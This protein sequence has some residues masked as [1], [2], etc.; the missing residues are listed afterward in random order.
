MKNYFISLL[1]LF[2]FI[3]C[4]Q[5]QPKNE[6]HSER[7]L[8]SDDCLELINTFLEVKIPE[9][10]IFPTSIFGINADI[11]KKMESIQLLSIDYFQFYQTFQT[12]NKRAPTLRE[13]L[14]FA[15]QVK[16][17]ILNNYENLAEELSKHANANNQQIQLFIQELRHSKS[18]LSKYK[19]IDQIELEVVA[20]YQN[21]K[22]AIATLDTAI[23]LDPHDSK[24]LDENFYT[25]LKNR[26][27]ISNFQ[28]EF[29]ELLAQG[30]SKEKV[31]ARGLTFKG[32]V[33]SAKTPTETLIAKK[34]AE[35][36]LKV[37]NMTNDQIIEF[38]G[39]YKDGLFRMA[40]AFIHAGNFS[41]DKR[42]IVI[43]KIF[44]MIKS[45]EIDLVSETS[46]G[47]IVWSEV[48]A[49]IKPI[50]LDT[51]AGHSKDKTIF[52]QL[53]EHK[54]LRDVLGLESSVNLRFISPLSVT[55]DEARKLIESIG[56]EVISA[57]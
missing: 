41:V 18:K 32:D 30:A 56:Y 1:F 27:S 49:Y 3:S 23:P 48:K 37:N 54:A 57:K 11:Y 28:G 17:A 42:G 43:D 34:I 22:S 45:K 40:Y 7:S 10:E 47:K 46:D 21:G 53:Q 35:L 13:T 52:D 4:A 15:Y 24:K 38:V 44:N 8:A 6:F 20:S 5:I 19:T 33:S 31:L 39:Q 2:T 55:D 25:F 14:V 16:T 36:S 26:V 50:T 9:L 29:G 51:I 12:K